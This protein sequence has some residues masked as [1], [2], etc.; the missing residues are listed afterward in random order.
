MTAI[1]C[2]LLTPTLRARRSLR[3]YQP[4]PCGAGGPY[5]YHNAHG[6]ALDNSSDPEEV[7]ITDSRPPKGYEA[8]A[9]PEKCEICG[10][11]FG[12]G[13]TFQVQIDRLYQASDGRGVFTL[14]D[15]PHGAMWFADWLTGHHRGNYHR[16][17]RGDGPHLIVKTPGGEWD[18]DA[19]SSNGPDGWTRTGEAPNITA[20]P[21]IVMPN[22]YHAFLTAGV[23]EQI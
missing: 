5:S 6:P 11:A 4:G 15:A 23:L 17:Q 10:A 12:E 9:W 14:K 2:F 8:H 3:R 13:S 20:R 1:T 21:S 18:I 7:S 22:G 19:P 16:T